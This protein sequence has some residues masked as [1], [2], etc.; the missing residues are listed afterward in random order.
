L[1]TLQGIVPRSSHFSILQSL[2]KHSFD[3]LST[4]KQHNADQPD[5]RVG[6]TLL[7][8]LLNVL[9]PGAAEL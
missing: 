9:P 8:E 7:S 6:I 2:L 1:H 4:W 3:L 5:E